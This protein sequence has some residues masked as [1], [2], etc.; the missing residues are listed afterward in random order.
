M[1]MAATALLSLASAAWASLAVF[2]QAG[3]ARPARIDPALD[4]YA[5]PQH[6]VRLD[7]GRRMNLLCEGKG[8]PTVI[9]EAGAG[10]STLDWRWVQS[11][12]AR[13]TRVCAYDRAGMGFSDAGPLPRT[14]T[15]VVEDLEALRR[16]ADLQPPFVLVAHSLGAHF[17]RLYAERHPGEVAGLVLIDPSVE[18]QDERFTAVNPRY[19]ELIKGDLDAARE[20][21][22]LARAGT[23]AADQAIFKQCTYGNPRDPAF[24]ERLFHVQTRRRLSVTFRQ[25]WLSEIE[26]MDG[27]D[28]GAM[29]QEHP[30]YGDLP[31]FVLTQSPESANA[32]PELSSAQ[33]DA[34]NALWMRMHDELAARSARGTNRRVERSGHYIQKDRPDVVI[35]SV[36]RVISEV[37]AIRPARH[38]RAIA[39]LRQPATLI[40]DRWGI[41]HI[42]ARTVRDAYFLQ[43]YNAAR[44]R[45]WQ[46]DLW[47]KR[48][49][50]LLAKSFGPAYV[51]QDR[52]ARLFLY[53][54]DI[55]RE[56]S[57]YGPDAKAAA[58]AFAAGVNA[59]VGAVRSGAQALPPEFR[60]TGSTP[61]LWNAEDIVRIRSHGLIGNVRFEVERTRVACKAGLA[62]DALRMKLEPPHPVA[63]PAGLDP[64]LIP[65]DVLKDYELG[66]G[67]VRFSAQQMPGNAP[68]PAPA[69]AQSAQP[70]QPA[71]EGSNNWVISPAHTTTGRAILANDPHRALTVPSLRYLVHLQAPGWS[72]VGAGEPALPGVSLGHNGHVGFG[73][74][75]FEVDQ[76]D[77]YVYALNPANPDEYRFHD[78]WEPMRVLHETVEVKGESPR[79]IEL[80]FTR[81]GPLLRRDP[82][83][84]VAFALHSVWSEPGTSPYFASTWL[85]RVRTWSAFLAARDHWGTPPLNLVYADE[86]GNIGWAPGA[87]VPFRT[88]GDGL[89]PVPGDGRYEWSGFLAGARLPAEFNPSRGWIATAN[90]MNLPADYPAQ[91]RPISFEWANRSRIDRIATVLAGKA[92]L[93]LQDSIALQNDDHNMLAGTL[94][95][96]LAPLSATDPAVEQGLQ[97]LKQWDLEESIDSAAATLYEVWIKEFLQP[98]T[99][100]RL[101]PASVHELIGRGSLPAVIDCLRHPDTRLGADPPRARDELLLGSLG[102][103]LAELRKR[104]GPDPTTWRW[105]RVHQMHFKPAIAARASGELQ[106]RLSLAPVELSG[107]GDSPHAAAFDAPDYSVLAGASVRIVLDVGNWDQSTAIN[108]PGQSGD[109]ASPHYGDLLR[110]WAAGQQV[111]L[112]YSR[113]AIERAAEEVLELQPGQAPTRH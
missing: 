5:Q 30:S 33:V 108:A 37:R 19:P 91:R 81:H 24:S 4:R 113:G 65:G 29:A 41:P 64:C 34:M 63:I 15:R 49:L 90:E 67:P 72:L 92:K 11:S 7:D 47:R 28:V 73:L 87:R 106:E 46:I 10:G 99:V 12:L 58:E 95:A 36:G 101:T 70:A 35:E 18:H 109:P 23:L 43:G 85:A 103:A 62:A 44:D 14:A 53:R 1:R 48:G 38:T 98:M 9:L 77:L 97:M 3:I 32:Y 55:K 83:R 88:Q 76:E 69:P 54:G 86:A 102:A 17:A 89:M 110:P 96:L 6:W 42:F 20:C 56:W 105:G 26:A 39:G 51:E 16:A 21:L 25:T 66:T 75:I 8:S 93:S 100:Q 27:A 13:T 61:D 45:L 31:L 111:P 107:S 112:L 94:I 68:S 22:R 52:A 82:Q 2:A 50:G 71:P 60:L 80:R 78:G 74:T 57:S 104:F 79:T 40:V 84:G 59:Y